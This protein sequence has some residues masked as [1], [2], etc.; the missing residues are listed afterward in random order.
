LKRVS[1]SGL[2]VRQ[3]EAMR[4]IAPF[5]LIVDHLYL[6]EMIFQNTSLFFMREVWMIRVLT[7]QLET[8]L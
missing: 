5:A 4:Y 6:F 7:N 2:P 8:S 1:P 3:I